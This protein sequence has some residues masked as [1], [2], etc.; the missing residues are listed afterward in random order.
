MMVR[1]CDEGK[2]KQKGDLEKHSTNLIKL[3]EDI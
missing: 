2:H 3:A 1:Y